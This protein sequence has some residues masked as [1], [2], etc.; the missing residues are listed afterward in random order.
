MRWNCDSETGIYLVS[1]LEMASSLVML[2]KPGS[3]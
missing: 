1:K 2:I 3:Y